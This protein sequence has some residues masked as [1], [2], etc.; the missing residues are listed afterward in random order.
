[1]CSSFGK[2][3]VWT[4]LTSIVLNQMTVVV[5]CFLILCVDSAVNPVH[6]QL[7][8]PLTVSLVV[9]VLCIS[10]FEFRAL[11]LDGAN[12]SSQ[13]EIIQKTAKIL[14]IYLLDG[15]RRNCPGGLFR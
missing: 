2:N 5:L 7:L 15:I 11:D 10:V 1:M 14:S 12:I 8:V 9:T 6:F 3:R 13:D 4:T